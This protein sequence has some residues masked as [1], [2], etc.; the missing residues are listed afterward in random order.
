MYVVKVLVLYSFSHSQI[1]LAKTHHA[2]LGWSLHALKGCL[3]N[4]DN[5]FTDRILTC[6]LLPAVFP[7][8]SKPHAPQITPV[9]NWNKNIF[10]GLTSSRAEN[11][12]CMRIAWI[13]GWQVL[14]ENSSTKVI[15]KACSTIYPSLLPHNGSEIVI[16]TLFIAKIHHGRKAKHPIIPTTI[17]QLW[18]ILDIKSS[19]L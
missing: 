7:M 18:F 2:S 15:S 1:P 10:L 17:H 11:Y 16:S 6:F 12:C 4:S 5:E 19:M 8:S 3:G 13:L 9:W 14:Q